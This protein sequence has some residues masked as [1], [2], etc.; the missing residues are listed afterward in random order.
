MPVRKP[1]GIKDL[2]KRPLRELA[3][4]LKPDDP[5]SEHLLGGGYVHLRR[6][7]H[8]VSLDSDEAEIIIFGDR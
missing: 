7:G 6:L 8:D 5:Q 2:L 4:D 3:A 1:T